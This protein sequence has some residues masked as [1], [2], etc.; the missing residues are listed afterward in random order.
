MR[1]LSDSAGFDVSRRDAYNVATGAA[2][3]SDRSAAVGLAWGHL[4][5]TALLAL[6]NVAALLAAMVA[7]GERARAGEVRSSGISA[8]ARSSWQG[9]KASVL[10]WAKGPPVESGGAAAGAAGA[11]W[12]GASSGAAKGGDRGRGARSGTD[13]EDAVDARELSALAG[14]AE[15]G[16][17]APGGSE[18]ARSA[19][20]KSGNCGAA[21]V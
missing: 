10:R 5:L 3:P 14:A 2:T 12:D 20:R 18:P 13:D 6:V 15:R 7:A 11:G 21:S 8:G 19:A 17:A 1:E 16:R 9:V 4:C